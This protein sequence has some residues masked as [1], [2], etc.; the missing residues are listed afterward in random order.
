MFLAIFELALR[1]CC[2]C[3]WTWW[4]NSVFLMAADAAPY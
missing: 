3:D 4:D 1:I 2:R